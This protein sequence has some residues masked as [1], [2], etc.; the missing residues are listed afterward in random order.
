PGEKPLDLLLAWVDQFTD[1]G[2]LVA[3][4]TVGA[5]TCAVACALRGRRFVGCDARE[6]CVEITERRVVE[7]VE[8]VGANGLRRAQSS[9]VRPAV[10]DGR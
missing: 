4:F 10:R 5:G 1:P 3:D 2:E 9:R 8:S 6:E 7:A